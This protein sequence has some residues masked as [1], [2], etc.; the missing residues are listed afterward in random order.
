MDASGRRVLGLIAGV[1]VVGGAILAYR[2]SG[3]A[4][5]VEIKTVPAAPLTQAALYLDATRLAPIKKGD[6]ILRQPVGTRKLQTDGFAGALT[7]LCD[8]AVVKDRITTVTVSVLERPPRCQ[9][10]FT[11]T[12]AA[13]AHECVS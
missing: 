7:R 9:C 3:D 13:N 5:Y 1:I 10:R 8:I 6:T 11:G 4:G 2:P 12:D